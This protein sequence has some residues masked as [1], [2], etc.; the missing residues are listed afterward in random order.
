MSWSSLTLNMVVFRLDFPNLGLTQINVN[1]PCA[2]ISEVRWNQNFSANPRM[3]TEQQSVPLFKP[4]VFDLGFTA[5][6]DYFAHFEPSQS[7][8]GAKT[9]DP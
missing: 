8:G 1:L 4:L 5:H 2:A 6:Q 9:G 7:L 3:Q